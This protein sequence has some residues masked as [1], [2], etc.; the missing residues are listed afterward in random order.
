MSRDHRVA[1]VTGGGTGIGAAT[2]IMLAKQIAHVAIASDLPLNEMDN[3]CAAL[4]GE[5]ATASAHQ[6]DVTDEAAVAAL[7]KEVAALHGR[8]DIAVN[9]AGIFD[10]TPFGSTPAA[11]IQRLMDVNYMGSFNVMNHVVPV[12]KAQGRGSIVNFASG[13]AILGQGGYAGYAASKAAIMHFTRTVSAELART[14]IRVNSIAPGP[15]RTA[16]T[17][18]VHA[19]ETPEM[20]V[21]LDR[22]EAATPSPYG[23]AFM[24]PEDMAAIVMFL[25]S[26]ASRAIHGA[27][28]VAD[29][30]LSAAMPT[31]G[32]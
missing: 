28:I 5:G 18:M 1:L 23:L 30:G 22:I 29:Q 21:A 31:L 16:M 14:G 20:K 2:A 9:S 32:T 11:R 13:A 3:V 12:M 25:V 19:P 24:E 6:V 27:C 26:D 4:T 7:I 8:I 17:E 15:I 10:I